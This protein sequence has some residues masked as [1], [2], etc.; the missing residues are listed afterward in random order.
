VSFDNP[1]I[2]L[3]N[4]SRILDLLMEADPV[5]TELENAK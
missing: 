5:I 4:W 2:P 3:S 1:E